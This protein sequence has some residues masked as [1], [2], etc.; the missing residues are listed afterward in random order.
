VIAPLVAQQSGQGRHGATPLA[1][2]IQ[3]AA[4]LEAHGGFRV[5]KRG[6]HRLNN[7]RCFGRAGRD[8]FFECNQRGLT[9]LLRL[10]L[11]ETN[12]RRD[13]LSGMLAMPAQGDRGPRSDL[14]VRIANRGE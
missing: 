11:H 8:G 4:G 7:G 6:D 9:D 12:E 10:V 3:R 14:C 5:V 1:K 13:N 2:H